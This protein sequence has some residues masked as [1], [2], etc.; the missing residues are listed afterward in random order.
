MLLAQWVVRR[1]AA[2]R[3]LSPRVLDMQRRLDELCEEHGILRGVKRQLGLQW[4][5]LWLGLGLG[6]GR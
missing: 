1:V 2:L 6:R 5:E 3:E 4:M